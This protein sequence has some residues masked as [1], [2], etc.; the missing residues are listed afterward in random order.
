MT[1]L[2]EECAT[3][4]KRSLLV[5]ATWNIGVDELLRH[6][7]VAI[8]VPH[9]GCP[10]QCSFCNQ[11]NITGVSAQP[12]P[13]QVLSTLETASKNL[14]CSQNR[15]QIA[16]FGGSFTAIDE[17]YMIS[18]LK[19]ASK[20]VFNGTFNGIRISTRPDAINERILEILKNYGVN[21]IELGA[22]SM[23]DDVLLANKRG[24]TSDDVR[25]A[26]ALIEDYGFSLGL[27]MMTGLYKSSLAKDFYTAQ[28]IVKLAPDTVRIYPT[29]IMR[30]T[31]LEQLYLEGTYVPIDF[32]AMVDLCS[33][34]LILFG[35]NGIDVIR[36]GLHDSASLRENMIAGTF[37]PAFCEICKSRVLL[38]K[39]LSQ[40]KNKSLKEAT[41]RINP[42][43]LSQ[44]IGQKKCNLKKFQDLG[45]S[46]KILQ[47]KNIS[48]GDVFVE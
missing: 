7:N 5:C 36:L 3:R 26:A 33:E 19:V 28:E 37:H 9:N 44:L 45:Y 25:T 14:K 42:A 22:Q 6:A 34:L 8:F 24:H 11:K 21:A 31:E 10:N 39:V 27:Q 41:V 38:K 35:D 18:L 40:L 29:V 48:L 43:M 2:L 1:V 23:C 46:L 16:F 47:D 17:N 12:T 13:E 30:G 32:D 4:A 15:A 20:F